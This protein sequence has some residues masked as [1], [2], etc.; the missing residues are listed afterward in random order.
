MTAYKITVRLSTVL[1]APHA[2]EAIDQLAD[3]LP[4]D[5]AIGPIGAQIPLEL[6]DIEAEEWDEAKEPRP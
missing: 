3:A 4:V 5:F 2:D 6:E 1:T